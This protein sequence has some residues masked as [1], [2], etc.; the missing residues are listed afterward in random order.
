MGDL[1]AAV[2][3]AAHAA[4]AYRRQNLTGSAYG[5][6]ARAVQLTQQC[7][8]AW[9]PAVCQ[10]AQRLPLTSREHEI[11]ILIGRGLSNRTIAARLSV[12]VRTIEGH[13]YRA[14]VKTGALSREELAAM[15]TSPRMS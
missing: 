13:I 7:G 1:V 11:A 3:A 12:S 15:L 5:C 9:T 2:D 14:M 8:G 6:S 10:A 4:S